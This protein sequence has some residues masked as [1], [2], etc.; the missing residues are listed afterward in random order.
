MK[1]IEEMN[2]AKDNRKIIQKEG[3]WLN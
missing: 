2:I 1:S 3:R